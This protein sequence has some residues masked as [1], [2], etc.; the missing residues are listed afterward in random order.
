MSVLL[1]N[2][3]VSLWAALPR[4]KYKSLAGWVQLTSRSQIQGL[5][6][7]SKAASNGAP[8]RRCHVQ[9][10]TVLLLQRSN[11]VRVGAL[12]ECRESRRT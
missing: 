10:W 3:W 1:Y 4:S 8:G 5:A 11:E 6:Q 2:L 7:A 12:R 9:E